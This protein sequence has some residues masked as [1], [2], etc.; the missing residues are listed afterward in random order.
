MW[1]ILTVSAHN[2]LEPLDSPDSGINMVIFSWFGGA[3][4]NVGEC[5]HLKAGSGTLH[6]AP[7][8]SLSR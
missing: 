8:A 4:D 5:I 6:P 1:A 3:G 2:A 7:R